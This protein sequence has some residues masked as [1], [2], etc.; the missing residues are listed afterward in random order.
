MRKVFFTSVLFALAV[1]SNDASAQILKL[2]P[3]TT[4][5]TNGDGSL[6]PGDVDFLNSG[7][8]LQRG[9]AWNPVTGHVLVA[10]RTNAASPTLERILV[11]DGATGTNVGQLD[12]SSLALG[13]NA[14]FFI[15][16]IG[17]ADDG[18]IYVGNLSN[19]QVPADYRLYRWDNEA[20]A[21]T[22]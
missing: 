14:S 12:L 22:L 18:A 19:A 17:V 15:N 13:G 9:L 1:F 21:Q 2:Q 20:A 5:G 11:L 6:R 7:G 8:Q 16:M 4:F 3:L 10:C